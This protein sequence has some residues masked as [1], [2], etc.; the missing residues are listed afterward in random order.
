[1]IRRPPRA[2][3][4]DT[5][6]PYTTHFRSQARDEQRRL[7]AELRATRPLLAESARVNEPTLISRQLHDLLGHHL[8]ALSLNL[9]V[10]STIPQGKAHEHVG[11]APTLA[12]ILQ[13]AD[14]A[15]GNQTPRH[16]R[17]DL[18]GPPQ[19]LHGKLATL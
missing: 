12:R 19:P 16:D 10:D 18:L 14:L 17:V 9:E 3:R 4:T 7:N 13:S 5:L 2:T 11:Q 6:F 8:T 1:M 15:A